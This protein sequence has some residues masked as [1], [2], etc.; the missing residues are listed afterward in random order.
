[1][2]RAALWRHGVRN[3]LDGK[4]FGR[5]ECLEDARLNFQLDAAVIKP[6]PDNA[7][8]SIFGVLAGPYNYAWYKRYGPENKFLREDHR[9]LGL[10]IHRP[11]N[12]KIARPRKLKHSLST[13][14][15]I[16]RQLLR[17]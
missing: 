17:D 15:E 6:F 2:V 9:L 1:M 11:G 13:G 8:E 12:I 4:D 7:A 3:D 16:N 5:G 10:D 14:N